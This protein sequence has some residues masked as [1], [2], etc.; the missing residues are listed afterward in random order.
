MTIK[1][2]FTLVHFDL[3]LISVPSLQ[4]VN[5][6]R[7]LS[8]SLISVPSLQPVNTPRPLSSSLYSTQCLFVS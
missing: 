3:S 5:T 2:S 7:P 1:Y 6:S 8:S 4:P